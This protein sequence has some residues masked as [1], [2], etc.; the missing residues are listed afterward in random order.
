MKVRIEHFAGQEVERV[1]LAATREEAEQAERVL[2]A[3][4]FAYAVAAEPFALPISF[5]CN[6]H[7][8]MGFFVAAAFA[9]ECIPKT[10][11]K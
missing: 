6:P 7:N 10:P 3:T 2:D 9:E 5:G 11:L 4:P 1:Y 8:G